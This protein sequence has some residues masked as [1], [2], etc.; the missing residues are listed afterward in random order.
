MWRKV[1]SP[2]PPTSLEGSLD[3]HPEP[4]LLGKVCAEPSP[5]WAVPAALAHPLHVSELREAELAQTAGAYAQRAQGI[6]T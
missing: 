4:P 5:S 3:Q 1:F 2:S 6:G